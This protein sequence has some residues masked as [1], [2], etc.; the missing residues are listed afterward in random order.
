MTI[1]IVLKEL[2]ANRLRANMTQ[3]HLAELSD[4]NIRTI[5]RIEKGQPTT[6]DTA[7][8]IAAALG[9]GH[10]HVLEESIEMGLEKRLESERK[11]EYDKR[12]EELQV[13]WIHR[14]LMLIG[15]AL[16]GVYVISSLFGSD[17]EALDIQSMIFLGMTTVLSCA[18]SWLS[19]PR[20]RFIYKI[21]GT[22]L[23][24]LLIGAMSA[25]LMTGISVSLNG[26][27]GLLVLFAV[28]IGNA[29]P[30]MLALTMSSFN[31][32]DEKIFRE[33]GMHLNRGGW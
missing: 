28:V 5:Q 29:G 32:H 2:K 1:T 22:G 24:S 4:L 14:I 33:M 9:L 7:K 18:F 16:L 21:A 6:V 17:G 23:I 12:H 20:N 27:S 3:A 8:G 13:G 31:V 25:I 19:M 11:A 10:Y 30:G 26:E 15:A